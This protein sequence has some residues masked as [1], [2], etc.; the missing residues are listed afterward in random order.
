MKEV[1]PVNITPEEFEQWVKSWVERSCNDSDPCSGFKSFQVTH[2]EHLKGRSGEYEIDVVVR[3]EVFLGAE[4]EVLIECKRYKNPVKRD[5]V[6]I[7][8]QKL[9]E[10]GAHKGIIFSTS[11]FQKGAIEFGAEH[12]IALVTVQEGITE[13]RTKAHGQ[14][15]TEP[16]PWIRISDYI[17]WMRGI[18]E[19]G[20]ETFSLVD[21][22][23]I[24][25]LTEHLFS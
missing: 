3:L 25:P 18:N 10:M 16:P 14:A 4:V 22:D 15:A 5:M 6:M 1:L 17:G 24:D 9:Q 13:Y 20:N 7:L 21:I 19:E 8:N 2:R 23:R 12:G 11:D